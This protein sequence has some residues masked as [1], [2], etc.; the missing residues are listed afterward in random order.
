VYICIIGLSGI[1]GP[2]RERGSWYFLW[3]AG[4]FLVLGLR[5]I[6][7]R[8]YPEEGIKGRIALKETLL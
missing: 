7:L 2:S 6:G 4:D 5:G 8:D 3:V 1:K